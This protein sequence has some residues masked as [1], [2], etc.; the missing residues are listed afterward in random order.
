MLINMFTNMTE[1]YIEVGIVASCFPYNQRMRRL[2]LNSSGVDN[3]E[4]VTW[5]DLDCMFVDT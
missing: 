2:R 1:S 4:E 5:R 3:L